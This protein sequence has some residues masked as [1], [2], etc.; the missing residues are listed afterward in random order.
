MLGVPI[1]VTLAFPS[2]SGADPQSRTDLE[3]D[4]QCWQKAWS[5][6]AQAEWIDSYLPILMSKEAIVGISWTHFS[7]RYSHDF[8]HAGL[9]RADGTAK[10]GLD[11]ILKY[12][13]EYWQA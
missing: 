4:S 2:D 10:P 3:V 11:H 13:R 6:E 7:D 1:Y 12:R 9:V 5:E 8:P